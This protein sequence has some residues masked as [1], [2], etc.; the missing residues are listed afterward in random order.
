MYS[1]CNL[2][3][4]DV[5]NMSDTFPDYRRHIIFGSFDYCKFS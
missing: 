1:C 3:M 5:I 4:M 2:S